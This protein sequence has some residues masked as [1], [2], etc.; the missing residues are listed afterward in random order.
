M[1]YNKTKKTK[2]TASD[3]H[4]AKVARKAVMQKAETKSYISPQVNSVLYDDFFYYDNIFA[5]IAGGGG[6]EN[7]IGE[8]ICVKNVKINWWNYIYNNSQNSETK[9][10]RMIVFSTKEKLGTS[11]GALNQS[12]LFR[13]PGTFNA[14]KGQIDLHKVNVHYDQKI[15]YQPTILSQSMHKSGQIVVK[16]NDK[17]LFYTDDTTVTYF[18]DKQYYFA[19]GYVSNA[20]I[21]TQSNLYFTVTVNF[22]DM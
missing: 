20:G 8:K 12:E 2:H 21:L 5:P 19:Y 17:N 9:T 18:K 22:T 16:F 4:I 7:R 15:V 3:S 11:T 13:L 1:R 14:A 10:M 6:S